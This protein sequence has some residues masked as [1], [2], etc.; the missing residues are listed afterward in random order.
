MTRGNFGRNLKR[1]RVEQ[2]LT[3]GELAR[4]IGKAQ[5]VI[6]GYERGS[7]RPDIETA[8]VIA[9]ALGSSVYEMTKGSDGA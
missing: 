5:T 6:S 7:C 4:K 9:D 3:Q 2:G 1:L 8:F